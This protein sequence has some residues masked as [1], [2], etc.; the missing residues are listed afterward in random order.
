MMTSRTRIVDMT[1]EVPYPI[2]RV[3]WVYGETDNNI[4]LFLE[5]FD[6]SDPSHHHC[7]TSKPSSNYSTTATYP[8]SFSSRSQPPAAATVTALASYLGGSENPYS[9]DDDSSTQTTDTEPNRDGFDIDLASIITPHSS[10]NSD[11]MALAQDDHNESNSV[12]RSD[13]LEIGGM[14][15]WLPPQFDRPTEEPQNAPEME[16][17]G[18]RDN[19]QASSIQDI[20]SIVE[21]SRDGMYVER[22][23][24]VAQS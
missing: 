10:I 19:T 2:G 6:E 16:M 7:S 1:I 23:Q 21:R 11:A 4:R 22:L 15:G 3:S 12:V 8:P 14:G 17:A 18:I 5:S 24:R 20:L 9:D 13:D